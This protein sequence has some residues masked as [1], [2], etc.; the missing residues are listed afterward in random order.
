MTQLINKI[1]DLTARVK[2]NCQTINGNLYLD[3]YLIDE[4]FNL[5]ATNWQYLKQPTV[6]Q[7]YLELQNIVLDTVLLNIIV[8]RQKGILYNSMMTYNASCTEEDLHRFYNI[9]YGGDGDIEHLCTHTG[10]GNG[11]SDLDAGQVLYILVTDEL[12][13]KE[14]VEV[15]PKF[16]VKDY[17][18]M[19][20][21]RSYFEK[22]AETPVYHDANH[23]FIH[24]LDSN[25][26][27]IAE[28]KKTSKWYLL[29]DTHT[30]KHYRRQIKLWVDADGF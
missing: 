21:A 9:P 18:D 6:R 19:T 20:S 17:K 29:A 27:Y 25:T 2:A 10:W 8:N 11:T 16:E 28:N 24:I 23:V 3:N 26:Y 4:Y 5:V 12:G 13:Q 22:D 1:Q 14:Y 30:M 7:P 15:G